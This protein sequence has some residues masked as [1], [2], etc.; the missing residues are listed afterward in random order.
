MA[1]AA[2]MLLL[3]LASVAAASAA[4]VN[5]E[6]TRHIDLTSHLTT[7][8]TELKVKN[9][10]TSPATSY[11]LPADAEFAGILAFATVQV[12]QALEARERLRW[13]RWELGG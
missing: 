6:A 4:L 5:V 3:A 1:R 8:K 11:K 9:T 12:R 2:A 10:G 13:E 7:I